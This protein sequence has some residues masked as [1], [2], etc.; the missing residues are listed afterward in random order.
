MVSSSQPLVTVET[1]D[2]ETPRV[3]LADRI[4]DSVLLSATFLVFLGLWQLAIVVFNPP[5]YIIPSPVALG[6]AL[7]SAAT[8]VNLWINIGVTTEEVAIAFTASAIL[9]GAVGFW[10]TE[11]RLAE[12]II[13]PYVIAFQ[14]VP[15]IAIAPLIII[16]FGFGISSKV[17]IA[18]MLGFFPVFVNVVTGFRAVDQR[19]L[20]LMR[21]LCATRWQIF[22]KL[23]LLTACPYIFAGLQIAAVL[24]S[25]GCIVGE[26]IGAKLGIG[27]MIIRAQTEMDVANVFVGVIALS[28]MVSVLHAA[29]KFVSKKVVF[30][31]EFETDNVEA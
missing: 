22:F 20:M 13:L 11:S 6:L 21:S 10:V 4:P 16:W 28:F 14:A 2:D 17:V 15:K 24:A 7:W 27:S 19:Q 1:E 9:A 18:T 3:K 5:P 30:W 26:F 8:D 23:R 25:L 31:T 12:R 29:V